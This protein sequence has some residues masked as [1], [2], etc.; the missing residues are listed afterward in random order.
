MIEI[1]H[2]AHS[3]FPIYVFTGQTYLNLFDQIN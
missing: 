1:G 2:A 3:F